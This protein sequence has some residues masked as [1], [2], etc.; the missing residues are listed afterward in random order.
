MPRIYVTYRPEDS[1]RDEVERICQRL[2]QEWGA[3][4]VQRTP[5]YQAQDILQLGREVQ[6]CDALILVVGQFWA[7][8][9]D[10]RGKPL[11]MNGNDYQYTELVAALE[12]DMWVSLIT[13]DQ[14]PVPTRQDFPEELHELLRHDRFSVTREQID[15]ALEA[16]KGRIRFSRKKNQYAPKGKA[17][18][19][20]ASDTPASARP[21]PSVNDGA[22]RSLSERLRPLPPTRDNYVRDIYEERRRQAARAR[23]MTLVFVSLFIFACAFIAY[24][25]NRP[26][27]WPRPDVYV[28]ER[29][30]LTTPFVMPSQQTSLNDFQITIQ[31]RI[32]STLNAPNALTGVM[33][34]FRDSAPLSNRDNLYPIP[35]APQLS[36]AL[37]ALSVPMERIDRL[38]FSPDARWLYIWGEQRLVISGIYSNLYYQWQMPQLLSLTPLNGRRFAALH[39]DGKVYVWDVETTS[40]LQRFACPEQRSATQVAS[41][42]TPEALEEQLIIACE[43]GT[44]VR[45]RLSQDSAV[46]R[47]EV[48]LS[49]KS[50]LGVTSLTANLY[51][52]L[53]VL[54]NGELWRL[55]YADWYAPVQLADAQS[56]LLQ[57]DLGE[58]R[59][60]F[61]GY[62]SG[63]LRRWNEEDSQTPEWIIQLGT[64]IV[65]LLSD[66]SATLLMVQTVRETAF[67]DTRE[68][69]RLEGLEGV[70]TFAPFAFS[71]DDYLIAYGVGD[72]VTLVGIP[73]R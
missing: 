2:E 54:Q 19:N 62:V 18:S 42:S 15:D 51:Q 71:P 39:T 36:Q 5:A 35:N 23:A 33:M 14:T 28:T 41:F 4:S 67:Y 47:Q 29:A 40:V 53:V 45:L 32:A 12:V 22:L 44:L 52:A 46:E 34:M 50:E 25:F 43:G 58:M 8:L 56:D 49:D 16:L 73:K 13:V 26:V 9:V 20:Y 69:E 10:E 59:G 66:R 68:G 11:L 55:P 61:T 72:E 38:A 21:M 24:N 63:Q 64:P 6:A 17:K 60:I 31:A 48:D 3:G 7:R 30:A 1:V 57:A 37:S 70:P 27:G 65:G